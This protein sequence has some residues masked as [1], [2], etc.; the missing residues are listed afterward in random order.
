MRSTEVT[1]PRKMMPAACVRV[2]TRSVDS[3]FS[4]C[5]IAHEASEIQ[6]AP[7]R[8]Q[9]KSLNMT[10]SGMCVDACL[11]GVQTTCRCEQKLCEGSR[12]S[13][14]RGASSVV[15][16]PHSRTNFA[17]AM[18]ATKLYDALA[19]D[20][21]HIMQNASSNVAFPHSGHLISLLSTVLLGLAGA[22][23]VATGAGK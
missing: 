17:L 11:G 12:S 21:P 4:D 5:A 2:R 16:R 15:R 18:N 1:V 10:T 20:F 14:I 9:S 23:S 3:G 22:G 19:N 6:T 7:T 8:R 13:V